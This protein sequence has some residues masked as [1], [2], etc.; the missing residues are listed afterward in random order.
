VSIYVHSVFTQRQRR[1]TNGEIILI[2]AFEIR[3]NTQNSHL[4]SVYNVETKHTM[5]YIRLR[6]FRQKVYYFAFLTYIMFL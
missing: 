5:S 2:L 3:Q 4:A 6:T 1:Q